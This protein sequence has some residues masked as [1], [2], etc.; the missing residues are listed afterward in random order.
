MNN[1]YAVTVVKVDVIVGHLPRAQSKIYSLFLLRN[2]T[3]DCIFIGSI[4]YSADPSQGGLEV[5]CKLLFNGK[6]EEIKKLKRL[7]ARKTVVNK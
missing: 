3:I 2:S 4:S 1:R 7:L 6:H 5:P